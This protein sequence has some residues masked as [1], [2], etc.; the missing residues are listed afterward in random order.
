MTHRKA[1]IRH[2][3]PYIT[4]VTGALA[5]AKGIAAYRES[6]NTKTEVLSLQ[7]YHKEIQYYE[8]DEQ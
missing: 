4:T 8:D 2:K 7:E 3:I 6:K 1:A 5:S